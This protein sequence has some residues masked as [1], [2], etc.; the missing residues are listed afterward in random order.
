MKTLIASTIVALAAAL[1]VAAQ[2]QNLS[3]LETAIAIHN[4]S[5]D[6][7]DGRVVLAPGQAG[8]TFS[9]RSGNAS[10]ATLIAVA[11]QNGSADSQDERIVLVPGETGTTFS[12]RGGD[13]SRALAKAIEIQN[14]SADSQDERIFVNGQY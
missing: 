14:G 4:A 3:P 13:V 1:P 8:E 7:Q 12:T 2:T 10:A 11:I 5:A 6:S 9:T